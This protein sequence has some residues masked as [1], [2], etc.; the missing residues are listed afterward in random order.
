MRYV[1]TGEDPGRTVGTDDGDWAWE[2]AGF[3]AHRTGSPITV[4]D[5]A[6]R[7]TA[8]FEISVKEEAH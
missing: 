5:T 3:L 7:R 8:R 6:E 2:I 4:T 1:I